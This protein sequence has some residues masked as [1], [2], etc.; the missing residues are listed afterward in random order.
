MTIFYKLQYKPCSV[1]VAMK[2]VFKISPTVV[3]NY[4]VRMNIFRIGQ[5]LPLNFYGYNFIPNV[6]LVI[7]PLLVYA[8][9]RDLC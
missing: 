5:L 8:V 4:V 1:N 3:N 7:S 9:Y 6:A 2:G